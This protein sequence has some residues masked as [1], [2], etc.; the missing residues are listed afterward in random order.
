[1][2]LSN[3]AADDSHLG[4]LEARL[5]FAFAIFFPV[6][7]TFAL[8]ARLYSNHVMKK[9]YGWDDWT[10]I[11]SLASQIGRT[12]SIGLHVLAISLC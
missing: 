4:R 8:A 1:M 5:M 10:V 12:V 3:R 2:D 9:E 7:A 6:L 11:G